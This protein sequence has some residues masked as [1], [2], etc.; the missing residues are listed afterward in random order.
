MKPSYTVTWWESALNE[1]AEIWIHS[2]DSKR[3]S[4]EVDAVEHDLKFR[5]ESVGTELGEGNCFVELSEII[6][7]FRI[8]EL[9][10]IVLVTRIRQIL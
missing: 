1:L 6:L 8:Q 3:L 2:L 7:Y 9:D 5:P 4:E 10:R